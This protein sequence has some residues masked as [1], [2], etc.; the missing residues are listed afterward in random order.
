ME[1]CYNCK[2][3][4]KE[5]EF[6]YSCQILNKCFCE[7]CKLVFTC[8]GIQQVRGQIFHTH[9]KTLVEEETQES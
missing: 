1:T 3:P 9:F 7:K 2:R 4:I 8:Q 6:M 5:G